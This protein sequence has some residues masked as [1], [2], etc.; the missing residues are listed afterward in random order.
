MK[1]TAHIELFSG[2]LRVFAPDKSYGDPYIF[3]CSVHWVD[4]EEAELK[5]VTSL[6]SSPIRYRQLICAV[7]LEHGVKV[8]RWEHEGHGVKRMLRID[9]ST[10][11]IIRG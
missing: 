1:S 7:L 8:M 2:C 10:G 11:R 5:G 6:C 9:T 3:S 4:P